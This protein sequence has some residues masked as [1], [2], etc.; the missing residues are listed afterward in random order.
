M[1]NSTTKIKLLAACF[2]AAF[3]SKAQ[4]IADFENLNLA[5]GTYWAGTSSSADSAFTSGNGSFHNSYAGY[6][7]KGWAYSSV[8]DS[9]TA[10]YGNLAAAR[11]GSGFNQTA[12]YAVGQNK[13]KIV[14][15]NNAAGKQ[16]AGMYITNGTY[17]ALS[18]TNG[19]SFAKK[20]GGATANDPDYFL[21][22]VK[23]YL[24]GAVLNDSVDFF[25]ADFRFA[26][27][28]KDYIVTQWTWVD[29]SSIGNVDS[30][31]FLLS[32]TDV[33]AFGMNTPAF[34]CMD[35]FTTSDSPTAV[36]PAENI[37]LDVYPNPA[38]AVV[39]V[40]TIGFEGGIIQLLNLEGQ[41]LVNQIVT[42]E[43]TTLVLA[44][45]AS[46]VYFINVL[47]DGKIKQTKLV[48]N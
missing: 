39:N 25:L 41:V 35:N 26:D 12:N 9:T 31:Q 7:S 27:N 11:A 10:G 16:V 23:G 21:L 34:F 30:L 42:N 4:T 8:G 19:D 3:A 20:F 46:G 6:W 13:A 36:A 32:S 2:V 28:S 45:Y 1:K 24:N 22:T 14:L 5:P 18:M 29:L 47:K 37:V 17:A 44:D 43:I 40:N 33:G 15:E 38:S 48:K